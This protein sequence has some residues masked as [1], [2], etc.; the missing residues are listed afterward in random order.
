MCLFHY[1][2]IN[3]PQGRTMIQTDPLWQLA[4]A[5]AK[6]SSKVNKVEKTKQ[7]KDSMEVYARLEAIA[8]G[9]Y[10]QLDKAD[11]SY[12][13]KCFG[14][15]DK[16]EDFM[17]RVRVPAGQLSHEQAQRVGEIARDYGRDY[18]DL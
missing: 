9:G 5:K 16:G 12:F 6:R 10:A 1:N 15:Y 18:I 11:S 13:L 3:T 4:D 8:N 17:L 14:L 2:T 7:S